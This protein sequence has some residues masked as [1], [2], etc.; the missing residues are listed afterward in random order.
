MDDL[1]AFYRARLDED[2]QA[3]Q[4]AGGRAA[5]WRANGTWHLEGVEHSVVGDGEA[6]CHP[7]NV[8]HIAR[9]DPARVLRKVEAGRKLIRLCEERWSDIGVGHWE[10]LELA[11]CEWADH[12]D[13]EEQCRP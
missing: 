13:Y 3:A 5:S 7:H 9:H 12:P 8:T 1:V 4:E 11:V 2:E 10:A 6:F